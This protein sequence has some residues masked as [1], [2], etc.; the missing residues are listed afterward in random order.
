M[1][2]SRSA[3]SQP[4]P[5]LHIRAGPRSILTCV[6]YELIHITVLISPALQ[7]VLFFAVTVSIVFLLITQPIAR[8]LS[9]SLSDSK[10][11]QRHLTQ[12]SADSA[13]AR[14]PR[15]R[16]QSPQRKLEEDEEG[17]HFDSYLE[18]GEVRWK[19]KEKR[20]KKEKK[21]SKA[22]KSGA[23]TGQWGQYGIINESDL[24]NKDAEFR[25]WLVEECKL[26]P[27]TMS[28]D[29]TK[30]QFAKFVEDYNTATLPHE[31]FYNI[32]AY[33][34]RMNL[35]RNGETLPINDSYDLSAD[36]AA[37]TSRHKRATVEHDSYLNREQLIELRRVQNERIEAGKMK[38]MGLEVKANMGVRMDTTYE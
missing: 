2:A 29:A 12:Y 15:A 28:K 23:V 19:R 32:D 11:E 22:G 36:L 26:N 34:R 6:N 3:S 35:I 13:D 33:E 18:A 17:C 31:K 9:S 4:K 27:E 14:G 24:Y 38:A 37:H 16:Q 20:D 5:S 10:M 25:T 30:K 21:K 8:S 7:T 1:A